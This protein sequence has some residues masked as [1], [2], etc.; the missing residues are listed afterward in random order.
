MCK[1]QIP[2]KPLPQPLPVDMLEHI[3]HSY[4]EG[5]RWGYSIILLIAEVKRLRERYEP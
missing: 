1:K 5:Y 3:E 2:I 4:H